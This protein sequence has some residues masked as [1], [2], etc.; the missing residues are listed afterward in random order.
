MK[1]SVQIGLVVVGA[2]GVTSASGYY[3]AK[4]DEA[5]QNKPD[6]TD[7][8][9]RHS[10]SGHSSSGHSSG[11]PLLGGSSTAPSTSSPSSG[12]QRSGFGSTGQAIG[13]SSSAS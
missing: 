4:R 1:R 3:M 12:A 13:G 2:L 11:R 7:Q 10:G 6:K 8:D 9:C 5:C